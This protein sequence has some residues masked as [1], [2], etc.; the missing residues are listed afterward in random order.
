MHSVIWAVNKE[1]NFYVYLY[2]KT[3]I[4]CIC[5]YIE[6]FMIENENVTFVRNTFKW[7]KN[8][9]QSV[10]FGG[11]I[12]LCC[13]SPNKNGI[14]RCCCFSNKFL[15]FSLKGSMYFVCL[16]YGWIRMFANT[17]NNKKTH[18][19]SILTSIHDIHYSSRL[20][21]TSVGIVFIA[22]RI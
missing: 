16:K 19:N 15:L 13:F 2:N 11:D 20:V 5:I 6:V 12:F 8:V 4:I 9:H 10:A 21:S 18:Y 14:L 7:I 3:F 17:T 22:I 1:L